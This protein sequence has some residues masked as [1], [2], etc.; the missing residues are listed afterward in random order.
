MRI[1]DW[2]Q[3]CAPPIFTAANVHKYLPGEESLA[4]ARALLVTQG[5]EA[6]ASSP[7]GHSM[8]MPRRLFER[9]LGCSVERRPVSDTGYW[10]DASRI[11]LAADTDWEQP[12]VPG[13]RALV[14]VQPHLFF[15]STVPPTVPFHHFRLAVLPLLT[16]AVA[17]HRQGIT[18]RD[19]RIVLVDRSE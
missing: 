13:L 4:Q 8:R 18:G 11:A 15:T 7:F 3:T 12:S 1:S 14:L 6:L 9:L 19:V 2:S 5:A 16:G 10:S 17:L